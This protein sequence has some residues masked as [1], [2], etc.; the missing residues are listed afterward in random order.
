[1]F[2]RLAAA[3]AALLSSSAVEARTLDLAKPEDVI[4]AE[5]RLN[6]A[7]DPAKPAM[8]WMSGQIL[9]RRQGELDRH[10]FNVQGLNTAACQ[11]VQ[12]A[13]RGPGYRSVTRE[14]MFYTDPATGKILDTWANPYTGETVPV[15]HMFNDPVNMAEPKHAYDKSGKPATWDG[16]IVNG[17]AHTQ[18]A[19]HFFRD[20]IMSGDYQDYVGGKYSVLELRS[21]LVPVDAWL[22]TSK[23]LPVRGS[24]V[25]SRISP[26]LPWMKMAGREGST[27]LTSTWFTVKDMSEVPEP[28][29]SEVLNKYPVFATAPPLD[30]TRP[31]VNSWVGVK[32]AIDETRAKAK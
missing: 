17:L 20:G 25:W 18:R 14:I 31:S 15:I 28:L 30:D 5:I 9:G 13:K 26:W 2:A 12:D 19:N 3:V 11:T 21:I 7:P 16:Q 4:A 22:D 6:C 27:A 24:S 29:R 10:L 8:R 23:P 1:M 32:K